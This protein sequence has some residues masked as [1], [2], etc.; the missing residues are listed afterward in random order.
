MDFFNRI[1]QMTHSLPLHF[2]QQR[3]GK[4]F[5]EKLELQE[6]TD[7]GDNQFV[8]QGQCMVLGNSGVGKTSLVKSLTGKS[9]DPKQAKTQ[10][11]EECLV[12][13]MWKSLNMKELVFGDL[14]RF[15]TFGRLQVLL[16]GTSETTSNVIVEDFL[17]WKRGF[18]FSLLLWGVLAI[19]LLILMIL[20]AYLP[21][22]LV[23]FQL[24]SSLPEIAP[25]CAFHFAA[26]NKLR[27]SLATISFILRR[28][29]YLIGVYLVL[30]VCYWDA[31]YVE[32]ASLRG[33]LLL[34][35]LAGI[36]LM[37]LF[38]LIGPITIP[39]VNDHHSYTVRLIQSRLTMVILC[40]CRLLLS[41]CIGL[42]S[43]FVA[44]SL[45]SISFKPLKDFVMQYTSN[46]EAFIR[47]FG[48][49][50]VY[51]LRLSFCMAIS[52]CMV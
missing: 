3:Q 25:F 38:L 16:I 12:D 49:G 35:L 33:L 18:Q 23:L 28:R 43:G 26:R 34:T 5:Y 45:V 52:S 31:T 1:S 36:A 4:L 42:I 19:N 48:E 50:E 46:W 29:G 40:L 9:F 47:P 2:S 27:F 44:A 39:F 17:L 11:I 37:G 22:G 51:F 6:A 7:Q 21:M 30:V 32:L 13:Q 8:F 20:N 10:G 24:T 14:W 15:F 41:I